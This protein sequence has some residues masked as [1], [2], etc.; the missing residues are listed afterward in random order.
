MNKTKNN[1]L[2]LEITDAKICFLLGRLMEIFSNKRSNTNAHISIKGPQGTFRMNL[3]NKFLQKKIPIKIYDAG[4]FVNKDKYF[5]YLKVECENLKTIWRKP[6]YNN[7]Y[8]PHITLYKGTNK[9]IADA[10]FNFLKNENLCFVCTE[11]SI[12]VHTLR[13]L[14]LFTQNH[15]SE[16]QCFNRLIAKGGVKSS[17]L[18]RAE[19]MMS[20]LY[21]V[22][23]T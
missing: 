7:E 11:Y 18:L 10:V 8:N 21:A 3:V 4:M 13:Q 16:T 9:R 22:G 6:D 2:F 5:V 15:H 12:A 23:T 19:K 17:I 1:I 20:D 14:D